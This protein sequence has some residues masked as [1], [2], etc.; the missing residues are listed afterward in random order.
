MNK[1][2]WLE[3]IWLLCWLAPPIIV[4]AIIR[5]VFGLNVA[6]FSAVA[7]ILVF[8]WL[9]L[10]IAWSQLMASGTEDEHQNAR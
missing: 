9:A 6:G 4:T 10:T 8:G 2:K 3:L 5:Q 1:P 7:S